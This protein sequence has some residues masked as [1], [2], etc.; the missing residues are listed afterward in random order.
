MNRLFLYLKKNSYIFI[1]KK[2]ETGEIGEDKIEDFIKSKKVKEII[3]IL[4]KPRFFFR[5]LSFPFSDRKKIEMVLPG[6]IEDSL[7]DE[8][9]KFVFSWDFI[10]KDKNGCSIFLIAV[11]KEFYDFWKNLSEKYNFKLSFDTDTFLLFN[12]FKNY[13]KQENYLLLFLD[14]DYVLLDVVEESRLSSSYSLFFDNEKELEGIIPIINSKD[15]PLF[16]TGEEKIFNILGINGEKIQLPQN[17]PAENFSILY[18]K[19]LKPYISQKI[20]FLILTEKERF[21]PSF[22]A[23]PLFSLLFILFTTFPY[24]KLSKERKELAKINEKIIN[25]FKQ[26]C[27]DVK[28]IISP[29]SQIK[30]KIKEISSLP[31]EITNVNVLKTMA[32]F[33]RTVPEDIKIEVMQFTLTEN[34]VFVSAKVNDLKELKKFKESFEK[35]ELFSDIRVS[36]ISFQQDKKI[37]FNFTGNYYGR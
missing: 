11:R 14:K 28:K 12:F 15:Y 10:K 23:L 34:R 21:S 1:S 2:G 27:P 30:E 6:E 3:L 8:V 18:I 16:W 13:I 35:S 7:P 5:K 4:S 22:I 33:I 37:S 19:Q 26:T 24:I 20:K 29:I 36:N 32:D 31:F 25:V 17:F 9:G